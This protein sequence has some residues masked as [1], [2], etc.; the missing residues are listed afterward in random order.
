MLWVPV[1]TRGDWDAT[2]T[3][4][5]L[6]ARAANE[7]ATTADDASGPAREAPQPITPARNSDNTRDTVRRVREGFAFSPRSPDRGPGAA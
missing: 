4:Y 6:S 2:A 3:A 7:G 1:K 5:P